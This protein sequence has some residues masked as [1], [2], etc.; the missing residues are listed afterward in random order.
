ML[1][2]VSSRVQWTFG[3]VSRLDLV[4]SN[5]IVKIQ[6]RLT[7]QFNLYTLDSKVQIWTIKSTASWI[8]YGMVS[9]PAR[10]VSHV[11]QFSFICQE[12][13]FTILC[14]QDHLPR[15]W[16]TVSLHRILPSKWL[17]E[18]HIQVLSQ[19]RFLKMVREWIWTNGMRQRAVMVLL[20]DH[21]VVK[22]DT[23]VLK[24]SLSSTLLQA[25]SF[26]SLQEMQSKQW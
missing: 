7:V 26:K 13:L 16:N 23:L 4:S 15:R 14:T 21:S 17:C 6:I 1:I 25:V 5:L 19:G 22:T 24:I 11:S 9:T 8:T 10:L 20:P 3:H 18:S 2:T 12:M